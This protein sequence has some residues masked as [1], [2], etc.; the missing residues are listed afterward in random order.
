[1]K[2]FKISNNILMLLC[3]LIVIAEMSKSNLLQFLVCISIVICLFYQQIIMPLLSRKKF[4]NTI[5]AF[6]KSTLPSNIISY[7][8]LILLIAYA[9]YN[10]YKDNKNFYSFLES[11]NKTGT[12]IMGTTF[13]I[14]ILIFIISTIINYKS[15]S[16]IVEE[17]I[18]LSTGLLITWNDI[19]EV[20][21]LVTDGSIKYR[22]YLN[23]PTGVKSYLLK[24]DKKNN[25]LVV[26]I[27]KKHKLLKGKNI[28]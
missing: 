27:F 4:P 7:G 9:L 11:F 15:I 14:C 25:R 17:G 20:A 22:I 26:E 10:S 28:I 21:Q 18:L 3:I 23:K 16:K 1:M 2:N 5:V 8:I 6:K 13:S 12:F 24:I 19:S